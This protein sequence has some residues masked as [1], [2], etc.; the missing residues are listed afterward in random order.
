MFKVKQDT[1]CN[2][3]KVRD[4]VTL[5]RQKAE[6]SLELRVHP[7]TALLLG[8]ILHQSASREHTILIT[9]ECIQMPRLSI[10]SYENRISM[11]TRRVS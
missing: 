3:G 2:V 10:V 4:Y 1:G 6:A 7:I 9:A 8:L 5:P 11:K